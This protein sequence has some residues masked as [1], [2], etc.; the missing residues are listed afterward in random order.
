MKK[1]PTRRSVENFRRRNKDKGESKGYLG[2]NC[3]YLIK[4]NTRDQSHEFR[5]KVAHAV[6]NKEKLLIAVV[7]NDE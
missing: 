1:L 7:E 3:I 5:K 2:E 6:K 4:E